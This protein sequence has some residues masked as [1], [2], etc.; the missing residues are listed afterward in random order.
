MG[1]EELIE[2]EAFLHGGGGEAFP[3]DLLGRVGGQFQVM[4]RGVYRGIAP[5]RAPIVSLSHNLHTCI[6]FIK[7]QRFSHRHTIPFYLHSAS[8]FH[9][10]TDSAAIRAPFGNIKKLFFLFI[11]SHCRGTDTNQKDDCCQAKLCIAAND[12]SGA[13]IT[14]NT[15]SAM[16]NTHM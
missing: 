9:I 1:G 11:H 2:M 5:V 6:H 13:N 4:E 12:K 8:P 14:P 7:P 15:R 3:E 10:R 16:G